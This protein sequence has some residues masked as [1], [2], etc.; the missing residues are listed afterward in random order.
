MDFNVSGQSFQFDPTTE[1]LAVSL[2]IIDDLLVEGEEDLM[3]SLTSPTIGGQTSSGA[4]IGMQY[5]S[6]ITIEDNDSEKQYT[7]YHSTMLSTGCI[8]KSLRVGLAL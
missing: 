7:H 2:D 5:H 4:Q 6:R 3:L 1:Q 8:A